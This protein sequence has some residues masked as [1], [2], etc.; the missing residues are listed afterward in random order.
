MI[1]NIER[2]GADKTLLIDEKLAERI[3]ELAPKGIDHIV[4]AAFGANISR[5]VEVLAQ[6]GSIA[7][8]A[9]NVFTP[10]IPFRLLVFSN[11]RIFFVGS[12]DVPPEAKTEAA[13]AINQAFE[14]G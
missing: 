14:A 11:A 9:T 4:E 8:Y 5:D 6:N 1:E 10:E 12:D 13:R 7:T 2:N 3:K